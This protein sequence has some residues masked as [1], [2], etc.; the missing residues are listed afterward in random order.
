MVIQF[1]LEDHW[2]WENLPT[3]LLK[4]SDC[5]KVFFLITIQNLTLYNF[6]LIIQT[7]P[8]GTKQKKSDSFSMWHLEDQTLE[9]RDC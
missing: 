7:L 3:L 6:Y 5:W 2:E 1:L 8:P 9:E 4:S